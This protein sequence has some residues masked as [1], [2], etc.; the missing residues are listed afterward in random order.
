MR[1]SSPR[2]WS[3]R[4]PSSPSFP[5]TSRQ[6]SGPTS[7]SRDASSRPTNSPSA[8][9]CRRCGPGPRRGAAPGRAGGAGARGR[10]PAGARQLPVAWA[11]VRAVLAEAALV[12][13]GTTA[14]VCLLFWRVVGHLGSTI[15]GNPGSDSTASVA[16]FW[17]ARHE[18][19]YH[20]L[21]S[22]HHTLSGAPFG[23]DETNGLNIQGMLVYYPTYLAAKVLGDVAAYNLA[24]LSGYVLS[25][26]AMYLL[27]R[28]LGCR[29]LV[30][31]WAALAA[32]VFP[33]HLARAE[34]GSLTH[35]E[36]LIL[37][38]LALVAAAQRP[39]WQ[40][41][42]LVG[43]ATLAC[44][45]TS[46]YFGAMAIVVT[47]A[48]SIGGALIVG[49]QRAPHLV[50]GVIGSSLA[51]T[52]L[53]V[54][55]AG[56][57][58]VGSGAGLDRVAG[59][60]SV[61]GLRPLE[62]VVPPRQSLVFGDWLTAFWDRHDHGSNPTE[63]A[64]YLGLLTIGLALAWL[65]LVLR[66]RGRVSERRR[67]ATVGLAV[68]FVV[69]AIFA[70]PS[71]I[72][73]FGHEVWTGSRLLWE[74]ISAFRVP[75]RWDPLLMA[76]IVPLAALGLQAVYDRLRRGRGRSA[77]AVTAIAAAMALSFTELSI[78]A[79]PHYRTVPVPPE[80]AAVSSTPRGILAEYPL[81][82]SD[83][84]RFRQR[85]H[86]RPLVNGA[87]KGTVADEARLVLLDPAQ[88]G[89]ASALAL[90]VVTSIG[91]HPG[92]HVDT[93]VNPREPSGEPG[94]RLVGRFPGASV[95][96]VVAQPAPAL[97]IPSTGGF[98]LPERQP[99]GVVGYPL[100][101]SSGVGSLDLRAREGGVVRLTFD[102][103]PPGGEPRVL[104]I[105]DA[106]GEQS[107]T[108][109]G[110]SP[111]SL[112]VEIPRGHSQL[113]VKTDPPPASPE[114]AIV[115]SAPRTV[116]ASGAPA[117]HASLVSADPGF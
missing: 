95:W 18:T 55:A 31:T 28:Y 99:D 52:A 90:L 94:Y 45:L 61:Y 60:L 15:V 67:V 26:A 107:F 78:S 54:I 47:A 42:A 108:L 35:V 49:R 117:L 116:R 44:W 12:L 23:W 22:T 50:A 89:T 5:P 1:G 81:G 29:P 37:L 91:I 113:L 65:V 16:W 3:R 106:E 68:T 97:V 73:I 80:Y 70:A 103:E 71:P 36:G 92:A 40:R 19:G 104:R 17:Q 101:S 72:V 53:V 111:V 14:F 109:D 100:V 24:V 96:E 88:Q 20:I 21:G 63:T 83:I 38:L 110:K 7:Q 2:A 64:N 34:H 58:G 9:A 33:W 66:R 76:A 30:A 41:Y 114:E 10:A 51:A 112:L 4:W 115:L 105:A 86:G 102:A 56:A 93:E 27:V 82:Y 77:L 6:W 85:E 25:G 39:S 87:P 69:G 75:S 43:A 74:V 98:G 62:L 11:R 84:Y 79:V 46:G 8:R 57:S 59:D 48:F 13:L 32:I